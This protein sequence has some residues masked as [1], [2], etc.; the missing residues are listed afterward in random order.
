V[1]KYCGFPCYYWGYLYVIVNLAVFAN[2]LKHVQLTGKD[3][4][5]LDIV[6]KVSGMN[7]MRDFT[8]ERFLFIRSFITLVCSLCLG[9][10][11]NIIIVRL[12]DVMKHEIVLCHKKHLECAKE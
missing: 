8:E 1:S 7:L 2:Q 9:H 5:I 3:L 10:F 6:N 12:C 11:L 4:I